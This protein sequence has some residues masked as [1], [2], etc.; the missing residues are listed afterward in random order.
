MKNTLRIERHV[1]KDNLW[2][3]GLI[4]DKVMPYRTAFYRKLASSSKID[5]T[6]L[7]LDRW[8]YEKRYDP[9]MGVD[10]AWDIPVLE[11]F[12]HIFLKRFALF[13]VTYTGADRLRHETRGR[14]IGTFL[15][16]L[17]ITLGLVSLEVVQKIINADYDAIII[18]GYHNLSLLIAILSA[19]LSRKMLIL[20]TEADLNMKRSKSLKIVKYVYLKLLLP[21]F[22][23]ILFSS[24]SSRNYYLHYGMK[25]NSL[26]FV[27]S[28]VDNNFFRTQ[29]A[30][31]QKD[32]NSIRSHLGIEDDTIVLLGIGRMVKRKRWDSLITAVGIAQDH[33]SNVA[34]V[35]V[36]NGPEFSN[37]QYQVERNLVKNVH[38]VGFK[39]QSQVSYF[40]EASDIVVQT[41]EYD[42]SPKALNEALNFGVPL[43]V[44]DKV[45]TAYDLCIDGYNGCIYRYGNV[46]ELAEKVV[47][48]TQHED[49]RVRYGENSLTLSNKW[50]IE[51]GVRNIELLLDSR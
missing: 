12:K 18:E 5:L 46:S 9:T 37:L 34:L 21:L 42:P 13:N 16:Y 23:Q 11:G 35:L 43:I 24:T 1:P 30:R 39:N 44:S 48:L 47:F 36:G 28:A 4:A 38:F 29:R 17:R 2:K 33:T 45:G 51:T 8:G 14:G 6:V 19:K 3:V 20:R 50:T 10:L 25:E 27:P 22:D 31:I 41:S 26:T 49:V 40:Y 32:G 15:F 7:F